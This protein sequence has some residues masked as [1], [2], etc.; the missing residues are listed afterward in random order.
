MARTPG[1]DSCRRRMAEFSILETN[2]KR[3]GRAPTELNP[4]HSMIARRLGFTP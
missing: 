3:E 1:Q 4:E 2:L